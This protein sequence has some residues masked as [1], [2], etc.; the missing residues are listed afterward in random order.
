MLMTVTE[1]QQE[2]RSGI[3][4]LV[5]RLQVR[6]GRAGEEEANAWRSSLP[7]LADTLSSPALAPLH[8]FFAGAGYMTLEYKLPAA[9][10]W[11]DAI[12]LGRREDHPFAQ[13]IELKDW[14]TRGDEPGPYEGLMM[15]HGAVTLHPS[16]QVRGYVE[17][18]RRF[19]STIQEYQAGVGGCVLFTRDHFADTY[20]NPPNDVLTQDYPCFTSAPVMV[21]ETIPKYLTERIT[22]PD[23][24]FANAF[25]KGRYVQDRGFVR[26]IGAQI[27]D[28]GNSPFEL[29]DNQRRAFA[30]T[31]G[32][33]KAAVFSPGG[34]KKQVIV[35]DGPPG[36]GKSVLAAKVW[37]S[38]AMDERLPD[39]SVVLTTTSVSQNSNW[40]QLFRDASGS[41]A[42]AGV[43]KKAAS[44][45]PITTHEIGQ[46]RKR[47]GTGFLN[48]AENWRENVTTLLNLGVSFQD[49]AHDDQ[50]LFSIVDE[51]HA[52]IN[53]E[54][55]E[56]RGQF[57]FAPTLG[58][59]AWHIIRTSTVSIFLLDSQQGFRDR[60][61][62]TIE[63]I[64]RW[65]AELGAEVTDRI[66]LEGAQFRCAG[67]VEY[68]DWVDAVLAGHPPTQVRPLARA[69]QRALDFQ[70]LDNPAELE[71]ALR[72]Q[73]ADGSSARLLASYARPWKTK[74]ASRPHAL[75][76]HLMDFH[77]P[78]R[79]GGQQRHWS[80]VWNFI[81]RN[82]TDYTWFVQ[83]T[84]GSPMGDDPLSEVGCP[85]AVR[86][87]DYDCVGVLWLS[88]LKWRDG[89][90]V[91]DL[92]HVY[93]TGLQRALRA[94]RT[95]GR[96]RG[97]E[98]RTTGD[99]DPQN[100]LRT[101]LM[102]AYRILLTRGIKGIYLWFEDEQT[103]QYISECIE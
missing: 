101:A 94:A 84:P 37:A 85:Y 90:W 13:V 102:Q 93:E 99:T 29:L 21:R 77:E 25:V 7:K 72:A 88:D 86:G 103:R 22:E 71:E 6:T 28:P 43:V 79:Q 27:L 67:S 3:E 50:Y 53:P 96:R 87:F 4:S 18:C 80:K 16:D 55:P 10:S 82:G 34:L 59:Q 46:L 58:P 97:M 32:R 70:I 11:C 91:V 15:R 26:Q 39:G 65:A 24:R 68:V 35:I 42:G 17:Y 36:S 83:A 73:L 5:D 62:T 51:A 76:P 75:A 100:T 47:H 41:T 45:I 12:L 38:L 33:V 78:Y 95:D 1:F 54:H 44:Y 14:I 40:M 20:N 23:E 74:G 57:G 19:H 61:N 81:P 9:S 89:A 2:A 63:D 8:L 30:M 66:S 31:M 56:G 52:L 60:E 48:D 69:W 64:R 49:G 98:H 92:D